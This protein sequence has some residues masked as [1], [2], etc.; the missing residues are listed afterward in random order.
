MKP[1][2]ILYSILL[3]AASS[4][5]FGAYAATD[6]D[7]TQATDA[8]TAKPV[9]KKMKPHSHMKEKTGMEP[10]QTASDTVADEKSRIAKADKDKTRHYHP[11]DAK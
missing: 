9:H 10:Q 2:T 1:Q 4:L 7:M 11:R 5:S 8:Q 6:A 3:A